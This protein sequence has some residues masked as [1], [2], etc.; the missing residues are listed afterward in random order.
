VS[1]P[2]VLPAA[3]LSRLAPAPSS[4][5][6]LRST[7]ARV[8][9]YL[10]LVP[11]PVAVTVIIAEPLARLP[12]EVL[13][14]AWCAGSV[15]TVRRVLLAGAGLA[16]SVLLVARVGYELPPAYGVRPA[17]VPLLFAIPVLELW[18]WW[19][20][21]RV[22]AGLVR[23]DDR[24]RYLRYVRSLGWATLAALLPPLVAGAALAGTAARLPYGLSAHPDAPALVLAM[25]CG[26]LL[27]GVVAIGR[28]LSARH[29]PGLAAVVGWCPVLGALG[30]PWGALLPATTVALVVAYAIGLVLAAGVLF[31]SRGQR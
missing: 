13:V 11:L 12:W 15:R 9:L 10:L 2:T 16:A 5:G 26:V 17:L 4:P 18:I 21:T 31:D 7:L 6:L 27:V 25:A 8:A 29:R 14:A 30:L 22:A 20:L 24:D 23:Y 3:A 28:L 19:H 1:A